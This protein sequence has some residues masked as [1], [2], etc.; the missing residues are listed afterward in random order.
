MTIRPPQ[1]TNND[2]AGAIDRLELRLDAIDAKL[3]PISDLY[4]AAAWNVRM[5]KWGLSVLAAVAALWAVWKR[6]G[7]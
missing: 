3:T 7:Q 4:L 2:L 1:Q 5:M 6:Q